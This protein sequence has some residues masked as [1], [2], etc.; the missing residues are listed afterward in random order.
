MPRD[1]SSGTGSG[2]ASGDCPVLIR[3]TAPGLGRRDAVDW[4]AFDPQEKPSGPHVR[5]P[6]Y[7]ARMALAALIVSALALVISGVSVVYTRSQSIAQNEATAIERERRQA[8]RTP[9]FEVE[10]EDVNNDFTFFRLWVR[11]VSNE[12]L[13]SIAV[14]LPEE[15][16]FRFVSDTSGVNDPRRAQSYQGV[17]EPGERVAWR[18]ELAEP[19][20]APEAFYVRSTAGSAQWAER[21]TIELPPTN[22]GIY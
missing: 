14:E 1:V 22:L 19:V 9:N 4:G 18:V 2:L 8:E 13:D 10:I 21:V 17:I 6:D 15:C 20:R 16:S 5:G 12:S 7:R 3:R 11:L